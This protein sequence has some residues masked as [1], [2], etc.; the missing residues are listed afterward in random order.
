MG[1]GKTLQAIAVI[2]HLFETKPDESGFVLV[3][4]TASLLGNW[5]AEFARFAPKR[6]VVVL[7]GSGRESLR[8]GLSDGDVVITSY[9]TLARDL[10]WHLGREYR[11]VVVDEASLM[12]NPDTDHARALFKLRSK[13]RI[14]LTGTP[15]ENGVVDLWSIFR[16]VQPGWLGGREDFKQQYEMPLR[17]V[18]GD[19]SAMGR[20]RLRLKPLMLRRSKEQV[21]ADLPSKLIIDEWCELTDQQKVVYRDLQVE[22]RKLV[23]VAGDFGNA[24]VA[25]MRMLTALLRLRQACCDL[26]LLGNVELKQMLASERSAKMQRL[27]ELLDE[28]INGNHKVLI[29]S[30]F[31]KQ[32]LEIEKHIQARNWDCLRLDGQTRNRQ[33]VV[34][35]FQSADGP[36]IFLISLKAGGYG[37]N[38]TAADVVIHFDPWWN[39]AAEAQ[40]TDRA[41]RIG[42]TRPVTV[43]RLLTRGTVEEKVVRMQAGKRELA[44][45]LDE[46]GGGDGGLTAAEMRS[47]LAED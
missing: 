35:K 23:Q 34:D 29:F 28:A 32:L 21:A 37:L 41:H 39:P 31:Q 12:R 8:E 22:G 9:G 18:G 44:A 40:A 16:F 5:R 30:Q 2:E 42:Q 10:V 36:P 43:Y 24:A 27:F 26:S 13:V 1:L 11:T 15:L 14:A 45:G 7:H 19:S 25:R 47:V 20:L 38:L 46:E 3:V 4:A 17:A 6:R 33:A